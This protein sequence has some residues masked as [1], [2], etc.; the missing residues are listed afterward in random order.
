M[1][2]VDHYLTREDIVM[3]LCAGA[4][5]T[6]TPLIHPEILAAVRSTLASAWEAEDA[7]AMWSETR[8]SGSEADARYEWARKL[9]AQL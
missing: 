3:L 7:L 6:G 4:T 8:Y 1:L 2:R 9:V 5:A